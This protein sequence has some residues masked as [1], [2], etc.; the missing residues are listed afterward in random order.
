MKKYEITEIKAIAE[1]AGDTSIQDALRIHLVED[2]YADGD[3]I[4]FGY[5]AS[6]LEEDDEITEALCNNTPE[7]DFYIDE[8]GIY[9]T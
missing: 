9:H 6:E 3:C 5:S 4:L 2:Q 7:S 1:S 8:A